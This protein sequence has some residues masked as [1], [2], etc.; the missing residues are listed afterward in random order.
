MGASATGRQVPRR[1]GGFSLLE[2][3]IVVSLVGVL[4][5]VLLDRLRYYEEAAEKANVEYTISAIKSVLRYKLATLM[6]EGRMQECAALVGQNPMEWL[7]AKPENYAGTGTNFPHGNWYF[8]NTNRA[9]VYAPRS[10]HYFQTDAQGARQIRLRVAKVTQKADGPS[11]GSCQEAGDSVE[12]QVQ[13][14]RWF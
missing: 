13:R 5:T 8:D 2:L 3:M 6:L 14:Y 10:S 7:D 9:L 11:T 1:G 12:I 4:A